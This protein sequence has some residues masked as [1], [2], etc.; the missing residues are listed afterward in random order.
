MAPSLE[1][2]F[3]ELKEYI[4]AVPPVPMGEEVKSL[5]LIEVYSPLRVAKVMNK[6]DCKM[7]RLSPDLRT[8]RRAGAKVGLR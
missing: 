4:L 7:E 8:F 3:Q 1:L 2:G 5:E 6:L